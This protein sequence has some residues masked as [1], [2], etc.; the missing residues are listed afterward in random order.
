M[1]KFKSWPGFRGFHDLL[2]PYLQAIY[3]LAVSHPV[4]SAWSSIW[5]RKKQLSRMSFLTPPR[6]QCALHSP[7]FHGIAHLYGIHVFT[8]S[9]PG[10][11]CTPTEGTGFCLNPQ[12]LAQ[13]STLPLPSCLTSGMSFNLFVSSSVKRGQIHLPQRLK[14]LEG[15]LTL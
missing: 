2:T 9:L 8:T 3:H 12:Y 11:D 13:F 10:L 6:L 4:P 1:M 15:C 5:L 7:F 14:L